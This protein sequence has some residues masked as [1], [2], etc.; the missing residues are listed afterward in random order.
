MSEKL[1][2]RAPVIDEQRPF[3]RG[4]LRSLN[5]MIARAMLHATDRATRLH[6]EDSRDQI[7]KALDPKFAAPASATTPLLPFGRGADESS[8]SFDPSDPNAPLFC[9]PDYAVKRLRD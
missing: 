5:Q 4:E 1:N 2:G 7:A 8:D 9:W 3:L 6:L